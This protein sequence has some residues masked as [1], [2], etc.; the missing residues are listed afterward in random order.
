MTNKTIFI[1]MSL[2]LLFSLNAQAMTVSCE[3]KNKDGKTVGYY[4]HSS[5]FYATCD[6]NNLRIP[7]HMR[8]VCAESVREKL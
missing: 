3:V 1:F 7:D 5:D 2:M 6:C 8:E 4:S